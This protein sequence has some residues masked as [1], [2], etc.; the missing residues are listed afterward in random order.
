MRVSRRG[1]EPLELV[2][3]GDI[4]EYLQLSKHVSNYYGEWM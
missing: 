1:G 2:S 4:R 3:R